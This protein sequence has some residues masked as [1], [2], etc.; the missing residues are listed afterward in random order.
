MIVATDIFCLNELGGRANNEDSVSPRKGAATLRDRLFVVCDGVGGEKKGEVASGIAS[1]AVQTF[2]QAQDGQMGSERTLVEKAIE[3]ANKQLALYAKINADA[4]RM[5]T[6]L[7]LVL[8]GS[9]SVLAAWCGDTRIYHLRNG[10]VVW[11]SRDHSLVAE[12]V[13]QG[14]LTEEEAKRHP[15]RNVITRSLNA[16]NVGNEIDYHQIGDVESG[17]WFL[18]CT[19]GFLEKVDEGVIH[20]VLTD[21][22]AGDKAKAFF[23]ICDGVTRDNFSMYLVRTTVEAK[24]VARPVQWPLLLLLVVSA[25]LLWVAFTA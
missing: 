17:D 15:R 13:T 23:S 12:L 20:R 18:L 6:T 21:E 16:L 9:E 22:T 14:E 10:R 4:K 11:R 19:D 1:S 3:H 24:P 7:A 2:V 5:S 8:F 25:V